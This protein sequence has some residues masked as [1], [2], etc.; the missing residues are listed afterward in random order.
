MTIP[1]VNL[2]N[3]KK[4][5][6]WIA[7][8]WLAEE[9]FFYKYPFLLPDSFRQ[10]MRKDEFEVRFEVL[11]VFTSVE[12]EKVFRIDKFIQTY[13]VTLSNQQITKMK[14]L[15]IELIKGLKEQ[16]LIR[17][18]F[19]LKNFIQKR[20]RKGLLFMNNFLLLRF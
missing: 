3:S 17:K 8:V 18:L 20:Y 5:K 1:E 14:R 16:N 9:I 10:K 7:E 19:L 4:D 15:F 2:Y 12:L 6:Y 13:P 11:R